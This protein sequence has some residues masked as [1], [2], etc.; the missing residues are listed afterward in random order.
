MAWPGVV[1]CLLFT[2]DSALNEQQFIL[3]VKRSDVR[4]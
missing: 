2:L 4:S 3:T 1:G